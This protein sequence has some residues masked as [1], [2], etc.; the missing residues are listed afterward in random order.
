MDIS[1]AFLSFVHTIGDLAGI[2]SSITFV[3]RCHDRNA[4]TEVQ[5][6]AV[7][8]EGCNDPQGAV[9]RDYYVADRQ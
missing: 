7:C 6:C 1:Y 9:C 8:G 3:P 4:P 5:G 2:D